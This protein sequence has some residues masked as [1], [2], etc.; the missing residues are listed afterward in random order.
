MVPWYSKP[1][2]IL[3]SGLNL[4]ITHSQ[5]GVFGSDH[6]AWQRLVEPTCAKQGCADD[7]LV[8]VTR[9]GHNQF[10]QTRQWQAVCH[11]YSWWYVGHLFNH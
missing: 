3:S 1:L 5:V 11:P 8:T 7:S 9:S 10:T 4:E 6:L 2:L